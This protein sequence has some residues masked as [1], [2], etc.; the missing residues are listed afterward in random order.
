MS[1]HP[2]WKE[3]SYLHDDLVSNHQTHCNQL[4]GGNTSGL[5]GLYGSSALNAIGSIANQANHSSLY[6]PLANNL[7]GY[8]SS[9]N[10]PEPEVLEGEYVVPEDHCLP[11][12][13]SDWNLERELKKLEPGK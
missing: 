4:L 7:G 3:Q 2:G 5:E 9:Q 8:V 13:E 11:S 12:P 6:S 1:L 10:T